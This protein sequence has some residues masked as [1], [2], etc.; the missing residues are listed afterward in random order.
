MVIALAYR[1]ISGVSKVETMNVVG[2]KRKGKGDEKE[3]QMRVD[4]PPLPS[5]Y[6][7]RT[8][9]SSI[10]MVC[11]HCEILS[12]TELCKSYMIYYVGSDGAW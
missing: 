3:T 10:S 2:R 5:P 9:E 11:F 7:V 4:P 6:L 1:K 12:G 8:F